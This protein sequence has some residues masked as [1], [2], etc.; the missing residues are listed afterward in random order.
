MDAKYR[1]SNFSKY[2]R[3]SALSI[4][5]FGGAKIQLK[6]YQTDYFI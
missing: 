4:A 6:E 5:I 1:L 3:E 2:K